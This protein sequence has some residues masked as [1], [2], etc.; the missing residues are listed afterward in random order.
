VSQAASLLSNFCI[1]IVKFNP[2]KVAAE[3]QSHFP[4][5]SCAQQGV[6]SAVGAQGG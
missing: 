4:A 5:G 3:P 1:L 6:I 2:D